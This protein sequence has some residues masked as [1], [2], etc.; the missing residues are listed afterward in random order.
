MMGEPMKLQPRV[1]EIGGDHNSG[2]RELE[3]R[4]AE[5]A[6]QIFEVQR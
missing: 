4:I 6:A 5:N 1:G 2:V 3:E